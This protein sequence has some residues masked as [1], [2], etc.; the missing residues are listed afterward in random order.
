MTDGVYTDVDVMQPTG[1]HAVLD[2]TSPQTK[3]QKLPMCNDT[4]LSLCQLRHPPIDWPPSSPSVGPEGGH[5]VHGGRI[6]ARGACVS[7]ACGGSVPWVWRN[8]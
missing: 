3:R 4:V 6:A 8:G 7:N 2:P 1:L 5:L